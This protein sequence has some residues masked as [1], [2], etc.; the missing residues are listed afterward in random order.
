MKSVNY[1]YLFVFLLMVCFSSCSKDEELPD[2]AEFETIVSGVFYKVVN[3]QLLEKSGDKWKNSDV[4]ID[5]GPLGISE[6]IWFYNGKV[7]TVMNAGG[8]DFNQEW[9]KCPRYIELY[10]ASDYHYDSVTGEI[11]TVMKILGEEDGGD[12]FFVE[13]V[14]GQEMTL[15]TEFEKLL[16]DTSGVRESFIAT[17]SP[18]KESYKIFNSNEDAIAYARKV[19][20]ECE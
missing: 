17:P 14:N 3:T 13:H 11:T 4:N 1:F 6:F 12:R 5:G 7:I 15:R 8:Y 19:M 9:R 18:Q 16:F 20:E 10:V 2:E